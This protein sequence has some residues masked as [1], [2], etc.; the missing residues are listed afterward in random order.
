MR[1][2]WGLRGGIVL[3]VTLTL[4]AWVGAPASAC[5][6]VEEPPRPGLFMLH[7]VE[8]DPLVYAV[9]EDRVLGAT[10]ELANPFAYE[11]P[12]F[13]W[14]E[15]HAASSTLHIADLQDASHEAET[16]DGHISNGIAVFNETI[17]YLIRG[18][19]AWTPHVLDLE[20]RTTMPVGIE[21]GN[22]LIDGR[23]IVDPNPRSNTVSVYDVQNASWV[24]DEVPLSDL[25]LPFDARIAAISDPAIAFTQNGTDF[26]V[27][28][29]TDE[30]AR[31]TNE[32]LHG[33][34]L[35]QWIL[36]E[37]HTYTLKD[38]QLVRTH[39]FTGDQQSTG[40]HPQT[41]FDVQGDIAIHGAYAAAWAGLE[42]HAWPQR[43]IHA[44]DAQ[45][46]PDETATPG[47]LTVMTA[48][49]AALMAR[50]QSAKEPPRGPLKANERSKPSNR[51]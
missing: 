46:E 6:L 11:E 43:V 40:W 32:P 10:C 39:L 12:Y 9:V 18:G 21:E 51:G 33:N 45:P 50:T 29:P 38:G 14:A 25:G 4:A 2:A 35:G 28:T 26:W 27:W 5:T 49:S 3:V 23:L 30:T 44:E 16:V 13:V 7:S 41:L 15:T 37:E 36:D 34:P 17:V 47:L 1:A 42:D 22:Y 31:D 24:L 20:D 48:I 8:G 19:S